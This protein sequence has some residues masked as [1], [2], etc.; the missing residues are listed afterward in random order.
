MELEDDLLEVLSPLADNDQV[1]EVRGGVGMLAAVELSSEVLE[2]NPMAPAEVY[3]RAREA[4]VMVRRLERTIALSPPLTI[5]RQ[6]LELIGEALAGA[7][8]TPVY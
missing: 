8:G 7:L 4:G 1:A 2:R 6:E 5:D 3:K